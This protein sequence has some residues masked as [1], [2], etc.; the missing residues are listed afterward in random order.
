MACT[1]SHNTLSCF[2]LLPNNP[3]FGR[4]Y[5]PVA[6]LLILVLGPFEGVFPNRRYW[7]WSPNQMQASLANLNHEGRDGAGEKKT[8]G[9]GFGIKRNKKIFNT[10]WS[11]VFQIHRCFQLERRHVRVSEGSYS[12]HQAEHLLRP[13]GEN[14]QTIPAKRG[15]K[16][17]F[18]L[19]KTVLIC[20]CFTHG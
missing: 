16:G 15:N 13:V 17:F 9:F 12:L 6:L 14:C 8:G 20:R 2:L 10:S 7:R 1:W 18:T 4:P 11:S 19:Q 5:Q 3:S